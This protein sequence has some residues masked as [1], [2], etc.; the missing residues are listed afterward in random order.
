MTGSAVAHSGTA[1]THVVSAGRGHS[2]QPLI[3]DVVN[4]RPPRQTFTRTPVTPRPAIAQTV[5]T[6]TPSELVPGGHGHRRAHHRH[7]HQLRLLRRA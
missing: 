2:S 6:T 1:P 7:H 5:V 4:Q 3:A